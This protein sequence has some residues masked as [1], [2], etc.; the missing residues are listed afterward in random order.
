MA[1]TAPT[2]AKMTPRYDAWWN[3]MVV[4]KQNAATQQARA[5][6]AAKVRLK[7]VEK[8]TTVPWFVLGL[9]LLREAGLTKDGKLDFGAALHNGQRIIGR[10]LKTTIVPK[11]RGP[12]STF[13]DGA[14]DAIK[15]RKMDKGAWTLERTAFELEG[16]NGWGYYFHDL[17][18]PYL[19]GGTNRQRLGKYVSDGKFDQNF[20]DPQLGAMA[21]LKTVMALDAEARFGSSKAVSATAPATVDSIMDTGAADTIPDAI[22]VPA[23]TNAI[24]PDPEIDSIHVQ[25]ALRKLGYFEVGI[26]GDN[27]GGGTA[28]AITAFKMD[29]GMTGPA[30]IDQA[31]VDELAKAVYE[32]WHRPITTERSEATA[33]T[34]AAKVPEAA[35]AR[36]GKLATLWTTITA[37]VGGT[38]YSSVDFIKDNFDSARGYVEPVSNFFGDIPKIAYVG[39]IVAALIYLLKQ[40]ND[41]EKAAGAA[42]RSGERK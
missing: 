1:M 5:V 25:N 32:D 6:I 9:M 12:F 2:L 40:Q 4:T 36:K 19:W 16:Y 41:S 11:G 26:V 30:V 22:E 13:E 20:L 24:T 23:S 15:L 27:P 29:R 35:A 14:V 33:Q 28:G 8:L 38:F 42:Y 34:I 17:P 3:G 10:G 7:A 39:L 37:A 21:I 31:L 18:S